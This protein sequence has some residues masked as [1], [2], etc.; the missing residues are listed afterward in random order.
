MSRIKNRPA[1]VAAAAVLINKR[2]RLRFLPEAESN[3]Q[4]RHD[5]RMAIENQL[6]SIYRKLEG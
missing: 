1:L 6:Q 2:D 4:R 5:K 3:E